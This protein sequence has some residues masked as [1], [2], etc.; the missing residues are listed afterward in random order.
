MRLRA[1]LRNRTHP[2]LADHRCASGNNTCNCWRTS[3]SQWLNGLLM[4]AVSRIVA[5]GLLETIDALQPV[6]D[7]L[8]TA[9]AD[10]AK[11]TLELRP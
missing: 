2:V 5:A 3:G 8:N 9:L 10:T 7:R 11:E 4:A 6:I 1:L